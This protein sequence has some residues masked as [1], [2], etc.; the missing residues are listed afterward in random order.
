[1]GGEFLSIYRQECKRASHNA[2]KA[3]SWA[4]SIAA[5]GEEAG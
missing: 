1:M 2:W 4:R 3:E 5:N